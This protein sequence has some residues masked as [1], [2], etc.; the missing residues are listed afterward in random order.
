MT[1]K[2]TVK[3]EIHKKLVSQSVYRDDPTGETQFIKIR[4][5]DGKIKEV[6][7]PLTERVFIP[8]KYEEKEIERTVYIVEDGDEIHEFASQEDA[9]KFTRG[10]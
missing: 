2:K 10:K 4:G 3:K 6:E 8:A 9:K 1:I 5:K 7:R